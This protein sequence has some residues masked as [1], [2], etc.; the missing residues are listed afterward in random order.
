MGWRA[1]EFGVGCVGVRSAIGRAEDGGHQCEVHSGKGKRRVK[2]GKLI[3]WRKERNAMG[4]GI[5]GG[6]GNGGEVRI[7]GPRA[8]RGK[9]PSPMKAMAGPPCV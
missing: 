1:D 4:A 5:G 7:M 9:Q 8:G 2:L 3:A 6:L